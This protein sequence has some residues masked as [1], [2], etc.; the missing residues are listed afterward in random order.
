M[1]ACQ[2]FCPNRKCK[3]RGKIGQGNRVVHSKKRPRYKCKTCVKTF[4]ARIGTAMEGIRKPEE[5]FMTVISL[6]AYGCP[7]QAIVHT[8]GLNER[9]VGEWRDRAGNQCEKV[10]KEKVEQ[11]EIDLQHIQAD[12]ICVKGR[13][14]VFWMALATMVSTH[15]WVAGVVS[16]RRDSKLT[17]DP[18]LARKIFL[19]SFCSK[20]LSIN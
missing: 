14:M 18:M 4:S 8:Y 12:E 3:S 11:G 19:V 20:S 16:K 10:Q 1:N 2:Q 7:I 6:L 15:L 5:L 13:G 9:T 17:D